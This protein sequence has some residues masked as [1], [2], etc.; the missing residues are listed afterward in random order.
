MY[1]TFRLR[2]NGNNAGCQKA[3]H[4]FPGFDARREYVCLD[5]LQYERPTKPGVAG[6]N[7]AIQNTTASAL[8]DNAFY[9][10]QNADVPLPSDE[11]VSS[12]NLTQGVA[13]AFVNGIMAT[14]PDGPQQ[15]ANGSTTFVAP[16]DQTLTDAL[17]NEPALQD[18]NV[19]IPD[20][21]KEVADLQSKIKTVPYSLSTATNYLTT[22][23]NIINARLVK[24]GLSNMATKN[25]SLPADEPA[26]IAA[27]NQ[28]RRICSLKLLLFL[29]R[30]R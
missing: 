2:Y 23:N 17:Q 27:V 7:A 10:S 4:G 8:G 5:T 15:D 18:Q 9:P 1:L 19:V 6:A 30:P 25:G 16:D 20:W 22:A 28:L 12:T 11:T 24:T 26:A 21:D 14:N 3:H 29:H 13:D